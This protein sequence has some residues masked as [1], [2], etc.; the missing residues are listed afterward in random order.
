MIRNVSWCRN[1]P[2]SETNSEWSEAASSVYVSEAV[3]RSPLSLRAASYKPPLCKR[4]LTVPHHCADLHARARSAFGHG[5]LPN[6]YLLKPSADSM[7]DSMAG[8]ALLTS[9]SLDEGNV[10]RL[11][12]V[13]MHTHTHKAE[14][15]LRHHV[16][17]RW[18]EPYGCSPPSDSFSPCFLRLPFSLTSLRSRSRAASRPPSAA[19]HKADL[20]R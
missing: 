13:S 9:L 4:P 6:V 5:G 18:F 2:S 10:L 12:A 8:D 17:C 15:C 19:A 7:A 14:T 1:L 11:S 16:L 20:G 3:A